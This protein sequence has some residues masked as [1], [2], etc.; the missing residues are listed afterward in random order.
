ML[1]FLFG[2][3]LALVFLLGGFLLEG[4]DVARL[5]VLTPF[6]I[7]FLVPTFGV[8][9]VWSLGDWARAWSLAFRKGGATETQRSIELWKFYELAS[10]LAGLV[11]LVVGGMLILASTDPAVKW[12]QALAAA[13]VAPLYGGVFGLVARVLRY[14][15][16]GGA[17]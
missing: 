17:L 3:F 15:V 10:Y 13:L 16:E 1:R 14:R 12:N 7:T 9:A 8:L 6:L 11:A 2:V 5:V 4:G